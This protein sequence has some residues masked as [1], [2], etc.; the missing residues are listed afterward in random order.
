MAISLSRL[1]LGACL[2]VA[3]LAALSAEGE[4][5]E[6]LM[7]N[8]EA[9]IVTVH[10]G[11]TVMTK[12]RLDYFAGIGSETVT[13]SGL[14]MNYDPPS[15]TESGRSGDPRKGSTAKPGPGSWSVGRAGVA[16]HD[17]EAER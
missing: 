14:S 12:Q 9:E 3:A 13:T 11:G 7:A 10:P 4:A 1:W 5:A 8:A 17:L 6:M 15:L 16:P 2:G